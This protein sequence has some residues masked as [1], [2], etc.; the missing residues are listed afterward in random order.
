MTRLLD[1]IVGHLLIHYSL[2]VCIS[3]IFLMFFL[4]SLLCSQRLDLLQF[5]IIYDNNLKQSFFSYLNEFIPVIEAEFTPVFNV[6]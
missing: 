4:I 3:K 6:T 1:Q 5:I 2:N